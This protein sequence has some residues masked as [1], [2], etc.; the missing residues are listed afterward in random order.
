V[1]ATREISHQTTFL[2]NAIMA[3]KKLDSLFESTVETLD[4]GLEAIKPK[5]GATLIKDWITALKK[6]EGTETVAGHLQEL[7]DALGEKEP[8]AKAIHTAIKKLA[9][10]T[11][12]VAKTADEE[13]QDAIK[14]LADSLKE[15]N[16]EVK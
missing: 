5:D 3:T 13:H 10:E 15:F 12:K 2:L 16:K 14:D 4:G 6:E 7:H 11:A 9:D 1:L 8:D